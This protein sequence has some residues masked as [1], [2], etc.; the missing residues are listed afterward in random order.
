MEPFPASAL[1]LLKRCDTLDAGERTVRFASREC[2]RRRLPFALR[3][4]SFSVGVPSDYEALRAECEERLIEFIFGELQMGTN[5]AETA[6]IAKD[7]GDE[8]RYFEA[9]ESTEKA[10]RSVKRFMDLGQ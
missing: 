1:A 7:N 3:S 8:L 2:P 10:S 5:L 9:K 4:C 6:L